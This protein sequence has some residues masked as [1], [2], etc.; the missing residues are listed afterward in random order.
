MTFF[1]L[2]PICFRLV[3]THFLGRNACMCKFQKNMDAQQKFLFVKQRYL[4]IMIS[5]RNLK[6]CLIARYEVPQEIIVSFCLNLLFPFYKWLVT[7]W[8]NPYTWIKITHTINFE[9]NNQ[10]CLGSLVNVTNE[11][12]YRTFDWLYGFL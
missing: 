5:L 1:I 2:C 6:E 3:I 4:L 7:Q 8:L 10:P 12:W 9:Q 11:S